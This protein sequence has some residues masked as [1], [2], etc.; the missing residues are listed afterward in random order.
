MT[1]AGTNLGTYSISGASA[2]DW[3]DIAI[4]PGPTAGAQYL[5]IG[6]IGDNGG[7]R[8]SVTV[9]RVP[10]PVVSSTQSPVTTSISGAAK[11]TFVYPGGPRDAESLF[12]D[13][14]SRDI[15]IISKRENPH[16]VYRAAYP[17]STSGTTTLE[18][19]ATFSDSDQF[20][21]ADI[22]PDGSEI[23]MRSYATS[24]GSLYLRPPGGTVA[25]AFSTSP[26]SIPIHSEGQGEAIGFDA[27]GW[28]YY[29][30]SE[31]SNQ[32]IYY[33]DRQ[34]HGD[35][36]HNGSV[37]AADYVIW[38]KGL[39]AAYQASDYTTWRANFGKIAPGTGAGVESVAVPEPG[40][41]VLTISC[42]TIFFFRMRRSY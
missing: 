14:L 32:P 19:V 2:T 9:Y 27:K 39:G 3:E 17:Q 33:F 8:S 41:W 42:L 35:F 34:P 15:Y 6:D 36:N 24:S 29:T 31:G 40:I 7:S 22:N 18:Q 1:P 10:E 5:Y 16:H 20:T 11:F 12:V 38:R 26:I 23:I 25:D 28:G 30:T 37:E 13:P 4:G 21:A